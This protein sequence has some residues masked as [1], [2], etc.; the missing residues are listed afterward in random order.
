MPSLIEVVR[1]NAI[2]NAVISRLR[3]RRVTRLIGTLVER[4]RERRDLAATRQ[5]RHPIDRHIGRTQSGTPL[6]AAT[7][8][9][10][11]PIDR[12]DRMTSYR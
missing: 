8:Q 3:A 1:H 11:H 12:L 5:A 7:R 4:N 9:A 2:G 6:I 10:R